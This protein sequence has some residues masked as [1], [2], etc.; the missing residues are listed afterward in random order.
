MQALQG[1]KVLDLTRLLPGPYCSMILGDFGAE[2]LKVEQPGEGDYARGY[3]PLLGGLGYRF[4]I[5][6]RNKK[7]MTL[8]LKTAKGKEIFF[9]LVKKADVVVESFRP[10]AMKRLGVDYESLKEI[11]PRIIF[12][13]LSGFGQN[14]PYK[15]E[16]GHDLNY[17]SLAGITS[18]TGERDG[19][20]YIPGVQIADITGG[21]MAALGILLAL[22]SRSLTGKGQYI[23]ISLFNVALAMLPAEA[24]FYFGNGQV[25]KRGESRLTG[26]LANYNIYRTKDNRYMAV[27]ALE[28]KFWTNLCRALEREDLV[29]AIDDSEKQKDLFGVLGEIFGAKT[30][31][32]WEKIIEGKDT[33]VTPVKN[34]DE[35]FADLHVQANNMVIDLT[36]D[37]LGEYRQLGNPLKLSDTPGQLR[38]KAPELGENTEEI[39][40]KIGYSA[41]DILAFK[42]QKIV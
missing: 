27:G 38:T 41:Q 9:R 42:S 2:V 12:C 34:I 22:Q 6:N 21:S 5:L 36:D 25:T 10:G 35:V 39:L 15:M 7:S 23:D 1:I 16:A 31:A 14:G 24:S 32:E 30:L 37:K 13:S 19:A 40:R 3:P 18:L 4:I 11:N 28:K 17:V 26:G 33:C 29:D 20:P 8:D